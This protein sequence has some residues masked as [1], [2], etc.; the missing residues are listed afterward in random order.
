MPYCPTCGCENQEISAF[1]MKCGCSLSSS[2]A[3]NTNQPLQPLMNQQ[4]QVVYVQKQKTTKIT[5]LKAIIL[6][7]V[8]LFL[9]VATLLIKS[10]NIDAYLIISN[11]ATITILCSIVVFIV[12]I[13]WSVKSIK[14]NKRKLLGTIS[15]LL[16]ILLLLSSFA[17]TPIKSYEK[18]AATNTTK[19]ITRE[20]TTEE[21]K[22]DENTFSIYEQGIQWGMS[23]AQVKAIENNNYLDAEGKTSLR[24]IIDMQMTIEKYYNVNKVYSFENGKL[25]KIAYTFGNRQSMKQIDHSYIRVPLLRDY[26]IDKTP[27]PTINSSGD[28]VTYFETKK[29]KAIIQTGDT[30]TIVFIEAIQ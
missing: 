8:G 19:S 21:E 7:F 14:H 30:G 23:V 9:R 1:C 10:L 5:G 17:Q 27:D 18:W 16:S 29:E 2:P 15:L 13:I 20:P 11:I 28:L 6:M 12:S 26:N 22:I 25:N 4:P 24:Y 3:T